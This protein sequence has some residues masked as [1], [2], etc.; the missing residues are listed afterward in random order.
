MS[1]GHV[2]KAGQDCPIGIAF[3]P[4][5]ISQHDSSL[6]ETEILLDFLREPF[7]DFLGGA[8]HREHGEMPPQSDLEMASIAGFECAASSFQHRLN[9]ALVTPQDT[10]DVLRWQSDQHHFLVWRML[11]RR[12]DT[13][14]ERSQTAVKAPGKQV[15]VED[16]A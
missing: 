13:R 14:P 4:Y 9:S 5:G 16:A 2:G 8:V 1:F 3:Q 10:T 6:L 12:H 7:A 15:V 11:N